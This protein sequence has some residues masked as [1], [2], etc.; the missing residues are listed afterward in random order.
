MRTPSETSPRWHIAFTES[1]LEQETCGEVAALGFPSFCPTERHKRFRNGRR[2]LIDLPLFPCYIFAR[3]DA[4]DPRWAEIQSIDGVHGVL[5]N[6]G[7]PSPV[8][9][10]LTEKLQ[11]MQTLGL[12]DHTKA[13]NPFPPGTQVALDSDGPFADFIGKVLRVRTAD[14]VDM[15]IKYLHRELTINVSLARLSA[16]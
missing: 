12:F 7:I 3:F 6:N 10:G 2:H 5:S 16:I 8:P 14:R 15:L 13:P 4:A 1:R 9:V 11:R